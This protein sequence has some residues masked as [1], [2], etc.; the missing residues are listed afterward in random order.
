V[1]YALFRLEEARALAK[2]GERE[3]AA[4]L[5]ME[6]SGRL[7]EIDPQDAGRSYGLLAE[8]Y[9][10]LGDRARAIELYE[11]AAEQLAGAP[12][13]YLVEAFSRLAELLEAEGRKD[14]ALRVLKQAVGLQAEA[15]RMLTSME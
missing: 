1:E 9:A 12:S 15:G 4:A 13:R 6:V 5:A 7:S 11:L 10:E 14:D 2:L 3:Q 8:I